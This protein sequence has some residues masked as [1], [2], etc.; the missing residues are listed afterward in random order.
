MGVK[1]LFLDIGELSLRLLLFI[2]Q[3]ATI[4][5]S[6]RIDITVS[7]LENAFSTILDFKPRILRKNINRALD[8]LEKHDLIKKV[9]KGDNITIQLTKKGKNF[10]EF[11]KNTNKKFEKLKKG[12]RFVIFDIPEKD[13]KKRN[14]F[15]NYLKLIGYIEFQKSVF[16]TDYNNKAAVDKI[17]EMFDIKDF[18]KTGILYLDE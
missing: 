10:A 8:S 11:K 16:I 18:V 5:T 15:R 17:I 14:I 2:L 7:D 12:K 4:R 9:K 3:I 6:T 13:R 1:Q